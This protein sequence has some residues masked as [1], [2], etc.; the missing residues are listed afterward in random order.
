MRI[1][2]KL[3][4]TLTQHLPAGAKD[5]IARVDVPSGMSVEWVIDHFQVPREQ[6][7]LVIVNGVF[8]PPAQRGSE[9][10]KDGDTLALWPPVA[11]G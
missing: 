11:G 4:A 6:C 9:L 5:N 3:F 7:H 10:L 1:E 2:L 8:V